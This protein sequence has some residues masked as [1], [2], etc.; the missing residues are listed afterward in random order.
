RRTHMAAD[1]YIKAAYGQLTSAVTQLQSDIGE[2][3]H[4]LDNE[5]G[6]LG[7]DVNRLET[8]HHATMAGAAAASNEDDSHAHFLLSRVRELRGKAD[9]KKK[10]ISQ[11]ENDISRE[12]QSKQQALGTIQNAANQ[13]NGLLTLPGVK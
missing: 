2:L 6:S 3:Q 7:S 4:R 11:L 1:G 12:I 10:Q 5:R 8:E 13:I 9:D